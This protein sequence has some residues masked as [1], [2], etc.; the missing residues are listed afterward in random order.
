MVV[1]MIWKE[2][3]RKG[4]KWNKNYNNQN[5]MLPNVKKLEKEIWNYLNFNCLLLI[6][7]KILIILIKRLRNIIW[8]CER[9]RNLIK[10]K[11]YKYINYKDK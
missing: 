10:S 2:L 1:L 8:K 11:K 6:I 7:S 9:H 3:W 5:S 4:F